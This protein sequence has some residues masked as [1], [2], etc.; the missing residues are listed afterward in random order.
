[1]S[2]N[3]VNPCRFKMEQ[4]V[5]CLQ[6]CYDEGPDGA[7]RWALEGALG[8]VVSVDWYPN[9]GWTIGVQYDDGPWV[10][11]DESDWWEIKVQ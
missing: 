3:D 10:F 8:T 11:Y 7:E 9:Q 5:I 1:M 2:M 6:A 4:R